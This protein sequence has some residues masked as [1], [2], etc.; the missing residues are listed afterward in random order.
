MKKNKLLLLLLLLF[1]LSF[2]RIRFKNYLPCGKE[3]PVIEKDC[4]KYGTDSGFVCCFIKKLNS[5]TNPLCTLISYGDIEENFHVHGTNSNVIVE[6]F[7]GISKYYFSCG[8]NS[9]YI[10]IFTLVY[11]AI[12]ILFLI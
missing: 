11:F 7:D 1:S 4:T 10:K 9:K 6:D 5:I 12:N 2:C 3:N 8:N